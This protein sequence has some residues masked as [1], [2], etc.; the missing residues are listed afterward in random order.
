M[1]IKQAFGLALQHVRRDRQLTQEDFSE[2][3]SRT[4]VSSLERG[5]KSPTLDKLESLSQ[6]LNIHPVTLLAITYLYKSSNRKNIKHQDV[7]KLLKTIQREILQ[8]QK[9]AS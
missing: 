8:V 7:E 1:D 6:E 2:V 9:V 4:Y 3:S 5:I